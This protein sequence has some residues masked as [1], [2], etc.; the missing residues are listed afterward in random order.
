MAQPGLEGQPPEITQQAGPA[1]RQLVL[2]SFRDKFLTDA[3]R[4]R[5]ELERAAGVLYRGPLEAAAPRAD[6]VSFTDVC[7]L[8]RTLRARSDPGTVADVAADSTVER[9][10]VPRRLEPEL[11]QTASVVGAPEY[12]E[13]TGKGGEGIIVAVIDSEVAGQHPGLVGRVV[14]KTNY[15]L[16]A[17]GNP[18]DHG[19][20]VA[21]IVGSS[22]EVEGVAPQVTIYNYKVLANTRLLNGD[23]FDGALAIQQALEDGAHI[24]NCSWGAGPATDGTSREARACNAAWALGLTLVKSAGNRGPGSQTLTT[25]ADADG[26]IVV[27]ATNRAGTSIGDYSSR[28]PT[29]S[30]VSRPHLSAPGG[31]PG[32]GIISCLTQG[33]YGDCGW[34]TSYAAPHIAGLAALLLDQNPTFDPDDLR[35]ALIAAASLLQGFGADDQ[36]AGIVKLVAPAPPT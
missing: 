8:N 18:G 34:G 24:A 1:A 27:G 21:G 9:V 10:D 13:A 28:G 6:R 16:E 20:A 25:P 36:G 17:F 2:T 35:N 5:D 11:T 31:S 23:D 12:R 22:G 19:T 7:W 3:G 26:V 32:D 4:I 30:G 29:R 14:H 15:T 33:G